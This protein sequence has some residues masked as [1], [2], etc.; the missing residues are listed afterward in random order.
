MSDLT[1]IYLVRHAESRYNK[2][3]SKTLNSQLTDL[4]KIQSKILAKKLKKIKI[5][6]VF[7]S[8]SIRAKETAE[9]IALEKK[10]AIITTKVL[11]E[12][13]YHKHVEMYGEEEDEFLKTMR[14]YLKD[15]NDQEKMKFK[16]NNNM[17]SPEECAIRMLTYLREVAVAYKGKS[18]VVVSHQNNM[19]SILSHLGY[20]KFDE[21]PKGSVDNTGYIILE[22]DGV[23]FFVKDVDGIE[24]QQNSI[25]N[26]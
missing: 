5:D 4:G 25:R 24:I 16:L 2:G 19:T 3:E 14:K 26:F 21:L 6:A 23:D 12:R 20:A 15:L 9:T 7:S 17:E 11:K 13:G 18:V 1:T 10:L 8:D 22:S